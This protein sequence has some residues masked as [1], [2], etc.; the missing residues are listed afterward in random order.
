MNW[1][2]LPD[3]TIQWPDLLNK[4]MNVG[5]SKAMT[6]GNQLLKKDSA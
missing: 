6:S 1:I 2:H 5:V 3:D 4:V